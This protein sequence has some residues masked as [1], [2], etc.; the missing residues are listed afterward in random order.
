MKKIFTV[1][2]SIL[3][4]ALCS[5]IGAICNANGDYCNYPRSIFVPRQ[6]SYNPIFENALVLDARKSDDFTHKD[7]I[8][9]AKPIYSQSVGSKFKRYFNI[10]HKCSLNVQENNT[11]D[12]NPLWF[13][14]ISSDTTFYSSILSFA[15]KR[16]IYGSLLYFDVNLPCNFELSINTAIIGTRN[17]MHICE[18][19]IQNL[20]VCSDKTVTQS[21]ADKDRC[22][23]RICGRRTQVGVDDIQV[24]LI[25]DCCHKCD[26]AWDLYALVGIPTGRGSRATYL[27]EPL[28][29][30]KHAQLGFGT[31][32]FWNIKDYNCGSWSLV[33][34]LKYRYAFK[35][36]EC[37]S[38][39]LCANGQW[40]RYM[41][42]VNETDLYITFPAI[43]R[44]TF[45][46][47]VMPG[48]SLDI[49]LAT[50]ANHN[51]WN[52]ELGYD[53]WYRAG[54]K[55]KLCCKNFPTNIG[56]ADL[57]G[58]A[59]QDPQSASTATI[60]Q[61]V[62]PGTNQMVSDPT[63]VPVTLRDINLISGAQQKSFSNSF[64][65]SLA[66]KFVTKCDNDIL[67]G[68][69]A[70]FELGSRCTPNNVSV[71]LNCDFLW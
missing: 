63:F 19:N 7:Y 4:I 41:L 64:Y 52:F 23:G 9:S 16:Q 61:G 59:D 54:E 3:I 68:V 10:C 21:F 42:F 69:N 62:L 58:I 49:Y 35:A 39:D 15:P 22:F 26:N 44:L 27:F 36:H 14:V 5:V 55:I 17:N 66:H 1:K 57:I 38:F 67:L 53:F 2:L 37:R 34:E 51:K 18:K 47:D 43:N 33:G 70:D 56:V 71:W 28:V 31:D 12:I 60:S 25:Y 24:K 8:F 13:S 45:K 11:G 6:L 30:S 32:M 29:G 46:A 40:S 20:G 50:H 65:G 48:S